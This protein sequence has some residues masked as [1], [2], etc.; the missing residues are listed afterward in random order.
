[1]VAAAFLAGSVG[2]SLLYLW[3]L[4]RQAAPAEDAVRRIDRNAVDPLAGFSPDEIHRAALHMLNHRVPYVSPPYLGGTVQECDDA[5]SVVGSLRQGYGQFKP[6]TMRLQLL[7]WFDYFEGQL[8]ERRRDCEKHRSEN[9]LNTFRQRCA[10]ENNRAA[11]VLDSLRRAGISL[12][13]VART[14]PALSEDSAE[15]SAE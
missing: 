8:R 13:P 9:E 14:E 1:V 4:R 12:D 11:Q 6:E 15:K 3:R 10:T 5:L 2:V 7:G